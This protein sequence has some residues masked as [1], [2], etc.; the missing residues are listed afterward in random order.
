MRH[1]ERRKQCRDNAILEKKTVPRRDILQV[2][3]GNDA[4]KRKKNPKG[5]KEI[6][7]HAADKKINK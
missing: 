4:L 2:K 5:I 1:A 3:F 7:R 6:R